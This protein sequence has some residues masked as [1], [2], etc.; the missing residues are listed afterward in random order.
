MLSGMNG[1]SDSRL[2][3]CI[4]SLV[5][6]Q[7]EIRK[8]KHSNRVNLVL[9]PGNHKP[10]FNAHVLHAPNCLV[11]MRLNNKINICYLIIIS[12]KLCP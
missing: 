10:I 11:D 7:L 3:I 9:R 5:S 12:C 8:C 6:S 1:V 2:K 4:E